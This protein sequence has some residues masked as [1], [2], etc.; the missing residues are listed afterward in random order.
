MTPNINSSTNQL[1]DQKDWKPINNNSIQE[2]IG[3]GKK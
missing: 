3:N 2:E 1:F